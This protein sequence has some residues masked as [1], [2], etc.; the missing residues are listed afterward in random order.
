M[1]LRIDGWLPT[2]IRRPSKTVCRGPGLIVHSPEPKSAE[3]RYLEKSSGIRVSR[4]QEC[5][6]VYRLQLLMA[7]RFAL[8]RRP[9]VSMAQ[10]EPRKEWARNQL[11]LHRRG[12]GQKEP[13]LRGEEIILAMISMG[14]PLPRVLNKLCEA[15]DLQIG[16]IV[17]VILPSEGQDLHT[18]TRNALQ[19]GLHVFWSA[20]IPLRDEDVLGS[21]HMYGC[22]SRSPTPLEL[23]LIHRVTHLAGL[24]IKQHNDE[25]EFEAFS[26]NWA[27]ALRRGVHERVCLN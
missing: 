2:V 13:L 27:T 16:N 6:K 4:T 23:K 18:I 15:I 17:S 11:S 5:P 7:V 20:S 24:A 21:L 26:K 25:G 22:V 9:G 10:N 19:F 1:N 8:F 14:T 12:C 3:L